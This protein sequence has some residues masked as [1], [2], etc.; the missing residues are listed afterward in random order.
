MIDRGVDVGFWY[1]NRCYT[2]LDFQ[3]PESVTWVTMDEKRESRKNNGY[4]FRLNFKKEWGNTVR[5]NSYTHFVGGIFRRAQD[6]R[7]E[8]WTP[9]PPPVPT[10]NNTTNNQQQPT[11][12]I[13]II[14]IIKS[15]ISI[16]TL[17]VNNNSIQPA[18]LSTKPSPTYTYARRRLEAAEGYKLTTLLHRIISLCLNQHLHHHAVS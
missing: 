9:S 7:G 10:P 14:F 13:I 16:S 15:I 11:T 17:K 18:I 5:R 2:Y 1:C 12:N 4:V 8:R 3:C 6:V